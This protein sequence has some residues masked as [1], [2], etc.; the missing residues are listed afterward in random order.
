MVSKVFFIKAGG[1][2]SE[3]VISDKACEL[4]EKG[5]FASCFK[6]GDFTAVKIHVGEPPNNT[7]VGPACIKGLVEELVGLKTKPFVTD[8]STLYT[9]RRH[10]AI[11][12]SILASEHGF[13]VAGLGVPFIAP[14][15]LFGTAETAVEINGQ[16]NKEVFIASDLVRCQSILSIAHFTGHPATCAAATIKTLGMGFSSRKGKMR[17]HSVL[18]PVVNERCTRCGECYEY[19][20]VD[21]ITVDDIKAHIDQD[22]CIGCAECLAVCRFGAVQFDWGAQNQMLHK[23]IAEHALGVIKGK[24]DRSAF[25]NFIISVTDGCDCF[26]R[27]DMSNIVDDIGIVASTDP[28]A[29]DKA[30]IDLVQNKAGKTIAELLS[31]ENLDSRYQLEHGR[32]IGLGSTDYELIELD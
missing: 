32:H 16:L 10:N 4:F 22:K 14:D 9:G 26:S 17:Q 24:E 31:N 6:A 7:Y 5:G 8:T 1:G 15:G 28:V 19:C 25:F 3:D 21:A 13:D 20:P 30:S 27:A 12:H 18:K 2:D 23:N 29:V 11:D